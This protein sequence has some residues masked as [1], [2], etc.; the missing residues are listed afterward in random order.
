MKFKTKEK[1]NSLLKV[2]GKPSVHQRKFQSPAF[3][4][5]IAKLMTN[6]KFWLFKNSNRV[7]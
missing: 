5:N 6:V 4:N 1:D 7:R 3:E 2:S